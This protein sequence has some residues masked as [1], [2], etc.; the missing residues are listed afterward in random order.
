MRGSEP[1]DARGPAVSVQPLTPAPT[2]TVGMWHVSWRIVN[3]GDAPIRLE[4]AWCPHGRFRASRWA[5]SPPPTLLAAESTTVA[6]D[7]ACDEAPG[8]VVENAFV[9]LRVAWREAP[10]RILVR[11]EIR[12]DARGVPQPAV[13]AIS[14]QPV[15][16]AATAS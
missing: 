3:T 16:F 7:V 12:V 11:L 13:M 4:A 14:T 10:W 8:T 9:I 15:G 6:T 2:G 1:T 5:L